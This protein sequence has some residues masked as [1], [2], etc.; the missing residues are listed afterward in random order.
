MIHRR[1]LAAITAG[2]IALTGAVG[3]MEAQQQA[4]VRVPTSVLERYV[5]EYGRDGSTFKIVLSGDTLFQ[6]TTGQRRALA[7]ISATLF[8]MGGVFTAEFVVDQAGGVTIVTSD[9]VEIEH[10]SARKGSRAAPPPPLPAAPVQVP[11]SVLEQYV[12][13]YEFIPGQMSRTDLRVV[14]RLKGNTLVRTLGEER[15]LTPISETRFRVGDTSL[16]VE[17]VV[18]EAGVTQVM[19]SGFQQLLARLP[20]KRSQQAPDA[21]PLTAT[22]AAGVQRLKEVIA[23]LNTGDYATIRAY[24]EANS[25]RVFPVPPGTKTFSWEVG[26]FSQVLNRY[27]KSHGVDLVRVTTVATGPSRGDVVGIVR[28]RLT[29]DE[30]FIAVRVEPQAPHRITWLPAIEPQ[31]VAT[32]G[33]KRAASVGVTE[34]ERLQEIGDHLKRLGD[35]DLF[36]GAVVIARDGAPVFAQA[37]GYADREKKIPNTVD[38]PFLLASLTKPFTGLAIG[39]LVEQ[40]KLSYDDPLSKFFP[41]F[42]DPE[43]AR[44]IRIKHLLSHTSG[45]GNPAGSKLGESVGADA[46]D[47]QTGVKAMVDTFDRKRPAFEPGA[48]WA[49]SNTGF[50]LLGR[51]IEIIT[52]EDYYDYMRKNV[53]APAGATTASFPLLPKNGVAVVPMAYPYELAWDEENVRPYV[54]NYL[55]KDFRRGSPSGSSIVSALDLIKLANAMNDGRIVKPET[56]RLHTSP[57]P[58]LNTDYGYGFFARKYGNRPFVG[59]GGNAMGMCTEFGE[60]RDTPYT[61]VVLSNL[62]IDTCIPVT[63]KILRVLRPS[64]G[65]VPA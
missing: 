14:V 7:P 51:I 28:N 33:L 24:F 3:L 42:P 55:G 47:R 56:F 39:Q 29:G 22:Q 65:K 38:T 40:G 30:E 49:Y 34:A 54:Q 12:G 64:E 1:Y 10:R 41:D 26:A 16:M 11:R 5:G 46:L 52:G 43:S 21:P 25:V 35:A 61:I 48:K 57:K 36:S 59:H 8:H 58:E 18:D 60:L 2:V 53:F 13:T 23:A 37:Y 32:W 63:E 9:G 45:L 62:T 31:I 19:G 6:E 15:V 4:P 50:V 20:P 27:R 17:F 44:K